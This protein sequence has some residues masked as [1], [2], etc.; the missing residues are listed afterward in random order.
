MD[1]KSQQETTLSNI[2]KSPDDSADDLI[3]NLK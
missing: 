1:Q 2:T 3:N